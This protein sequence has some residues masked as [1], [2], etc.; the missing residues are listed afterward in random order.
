LLPFFPGARK[1]GLGLILAHQEL[2]QLASR[3]S[4]VASAVISNPFTRVCFRLG[5]SDA[6]KLEDGFSFFKA[7]DL[8]NLGLGEA[9]CRVERSEYDFNLKTFPLPMATPEA[10]EERRAQVVAH[11]RDR[12]AVQKAVAASAIFQD[13]ASAIAE[14][15]PT[16]KRHTTKT[17]TVF[18]TSES[19][20]STSALTVSVVSPLPGR[21]GQQHKY[22]QQL[23]KRWA[24]NRG[25]TVTVEKPI[26]GGLGLVDVA[27]EKADRAIAC[28]ISVTTEAEHEAGNV[29]KC[30]A[31]GFDQV[32][33]VSSDKKVLSKIHGA[34]AEAVSKE[35]LKKVR[36]MAPEELFS[37]I[38]CL[39]ASVS[40]SAATGSSKD[41]LTAKELEEL[42]RI[43]V[44][45]I[46]S[47]A[48][49]GLIPYVKIQ[50]NLRFVR[51]DIMTWM[52]ERGYKPKP[53]AA[54]KG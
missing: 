26:L 14:T 27:L 33:V 46:Y 45:T 34:V 42:L 17:V 41:L 12:Y 43:D 52:A 21:G 35:Q 50:S 53:R 38:E 7:R 48:Q 24:E 23:I 28:E 30:L 9:I 6:R 19:P 22:L 20:E 10:A 3:D 5:D 1:Y 18:Q 40:A 37:F 36:F 51:A 4:D 39:E 47:Y 16:P 44:K 54:R 29:Q 31:G 8:Q 13:S 15:I 49:R 32:I 11:S 2:H 25:Y